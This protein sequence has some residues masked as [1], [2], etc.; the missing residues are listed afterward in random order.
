MEK[1][2]YTFSNAIKS[3]Y[4]N[5]F[6]F[7][8]T[9]N[10]SEFWFVVLYNI[11]IVVTVAL[12]PEEPDSFIGSFLLIISGILY[13]ANIIPFI[14]ISVRRLHDTNRSGWNLLWSL[15]GIGLIVVLI[16]MA[17]QSRPNHWENST[18]S[19]DSKFCSSCGDEIFKNS[20]FCSS[21]GIKI[22]ESESGD[23]SKKD[24]SSGK[25]LLP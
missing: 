3:F 24:I 19:D 22:D 21:C 13:L 5:Y 17:G 18:H 11:P 12:V 16:W 9:S 4:S 7:R 8:G 14:A 23:E 25:T 15:I 20:Q 6:N 1:M 2:I 10:R